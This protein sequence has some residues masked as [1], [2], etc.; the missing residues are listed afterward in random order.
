MNKQCFL[1]VLHGVSRGFAMFCG[2]CALGL[3]RCRQTSPFKRGLF[4]RHLVQCHLL[5]LRGG[6]CNWVAFCFHARECFL[7]SRIVVS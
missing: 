5:C 3:A 7:G 4:L 1:G 6:R 2:A